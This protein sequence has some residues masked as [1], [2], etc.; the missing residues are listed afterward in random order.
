MKV[1]KRWHSNL[2]L[3]PLYNYITCIFN[4]NFNWQ[5]LFVRLASLQRA[6]AI[7]SRHL[8]DS[9]FTVTVEVLW[10]KALVLT[11]VI[12][13]TGLAVW[14]FPS[15]QWTTHWHPLLRSH[16]LWK[17]LSMPTAGH[18][19]TVICWAQLE[20]ESFWLET[21]QVQT[22][23][24]ELQWNVLKWD[25]LLLTVYFWPMYQFLFLSFRHQ[26][27]CYVSWILYFHLDLWCGASKVI[28]V[29]EN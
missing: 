3:S 6:T 16:E 21:Q 22:W 1:S 11:N 28:S 12:C 14:V 2:I 10:P 24:L 15:S 4:P 8:E 19:R 5:F 20:N 18:D 26:L 17:K 9:W 29:N 27:D 7:V 25:Y 23:T 13:V